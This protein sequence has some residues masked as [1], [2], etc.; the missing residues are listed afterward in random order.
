MGLKVY[1]DP[2]N[3]FAQFFDIDQFFEVNADMRIAEDQKQPFSKT[4]GAIWQHLAERF[5]GR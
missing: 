3:F 2:E 5:G 4:D 1:K